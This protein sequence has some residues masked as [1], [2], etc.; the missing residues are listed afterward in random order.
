MA[1]VQLSDVSFGY[2]ERALFCGLD[3]ELA[4]GKVTSIIG[5]NGCGKSSLLKLAS[6]ICKPWEGSIRVLGHDASALSSKERARLLSLLAQ[7]HAA[8]PMSVRRLVECGRFPHHG[9][10]VTMDA[11]DYEVVD[12]ALATCGLAELAEHP[13]AELSGGQRQRAFIAMVLAQDAPVVL[14]DE[15]TSFLDVSACYEV[16]ELMNSLKEEH[17][18]T[19]VAVIHDINLA[20]KYSD[21]VC[22]MRAGKLLA[23]GAPHEAEVLA[24]VEDAFDVRIELLHGELGSSYALWR[25]TKR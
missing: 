23:Q 20:L 11:A 14:F 25:R 9:M 16:M 12:R 13:V 8:P 1:S 24:A 15:P 4:Q 3:L 10:F 7:E 21:E 17:G 6:G 18:K 22:V 19:V 5:P 2:G